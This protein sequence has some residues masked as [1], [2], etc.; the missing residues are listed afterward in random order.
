MEV[1]LTV[2]VSAIM[3]GIAIGINYFNGE[4]GVKGKKAAD[5]RKRKA[6]AKYNKPIEEMTPREKAKKMS[7]VEQMYNHGDLTLAQYDAL[8]SKYT[9][10]KSMAD[11]YGLDFV[12]AASDK[13]AVEMAIEKHQK[14]TE[15]SIITN[16][17]VGNAIGGL[18][19]G[20]AGA[21][22]SATKANIE[23]EQLLEEKRKVDKRYEAALKRSI[24]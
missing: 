14:E 16:A 17:A 1:I 12:M 20:I 10:E 24:K 18:S 21:V 2:V 5:E 15:K 9:G 11:T 23:A 7:L 8:K 13:L 4:Y 22:S 19:G 3:I 6:E